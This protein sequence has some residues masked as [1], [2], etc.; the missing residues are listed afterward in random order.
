MSGQVTTSD[1]VSLIKDINSRIDKVDIKNKSFYNDTLTYILS[2][3]LDLY[4]NITKQVSFS[5]YQKI[6]QTQLS[7]VN[8]LKNSM[9][10]ID[11]DILN[12][13]SIGDN[14]TEWKL[15]IITNK[16]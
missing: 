16:D 9:D 13:E 15:P 10:N 6:K 1:I 5:Q 12:K 7:F 14:P 11:I 4:E 2:K 8:I 3:Y